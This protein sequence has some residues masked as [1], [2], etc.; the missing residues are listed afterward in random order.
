[1]RICAE[2]ESSLEVASRPARHKSAGPTF[3]GRL[4]GVCSEGRLRALVSRAAAFFVFYEEDAY[5]GFVF[6][7]GGFAVDHCAA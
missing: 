2:P 1:M 6:F 4:S 3:G 5:A 7:W